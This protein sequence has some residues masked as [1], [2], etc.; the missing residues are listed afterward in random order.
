MARKRRKFIS[1]CNQIIQGSIMLVVTLLL[2]DPVSILSLQQAGW[3][4][5]SHMLCTCSVCRE[6][7][8][9]SHYCMCDMMK[10]GQNN[11]KNEHQICHCNQHGSA[12]MA[13]YY[14]P[15]YYPRRWTTVKSPQ[16]GHLAHVPADF[17]LHDLSNISGVFHPPK[18]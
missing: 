7:P 10:R 9:K 4:E 18:I 17:H 1:N 5:G 12:S 11:G 3:S 13:G 2:T 16:S 6:G 8:G 15:Y 14:F